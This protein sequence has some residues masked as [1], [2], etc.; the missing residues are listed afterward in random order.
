MREREDGFGPPALL[1]EPA[2]PRPDELRSLHDRLAS[3]AEAAGVLDVAFCT[4][5]SPVGK[6]LLAATRRGLVRIAFEAEGFDVVLADLA[7]RISPRILR[8]PRHLDSAVVQLDA[9]FA[10]VSESF[11]L[12]L[13]LSLSSGFRRKVLDYLPNIDYGRTL[14]YGEVAS[15]IESPRAARAVGSACAANPLPLV[16]PCHRVIRSDGVLGSY[17]GGAEAKAKLLELEAAA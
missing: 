4:M 6:L 8:A 1:D 11:T 15:A 17:L 10:G 9:Y 3:E 13:D 12:P 14:S 16:I 5:D 7:S 2:A